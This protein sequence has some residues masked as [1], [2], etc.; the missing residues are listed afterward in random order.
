MNTGLDDVSITAE[1]AVGIVT[2]SRPPNNFFDVKL[3]AALAEALEEI[4]RQPALRAVMVCS[5]GKVFCAGARFAG[6]NGSG[7]PTGAGDFS[8]P[9]SLYMNGVRLFRTH[10]P[11]VAAIQGPA[12][13]GGLGLAMIADFRIAAPEARFACNFV[14]L[15]I[16]PGFGLTYTLP[17]AIGNQSATMLLYS[18]RRINGQEAHRLGLVDALSPLSELNEA[19]LGFAREIAMN[20]PLAVEAT[21]RTMRDTLGDAVERQVER[22]CVEQMALFATEDFKEGIKAVAERRPGRWIRG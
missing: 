5:T 8:N 6:A 22:E 7:A 12:I 21:R 17:R 14:T 15:G 19:A 9:R 2:F 11:I 10:K 20:A 4:D 3:V 18:G 13:G 16:H 1:G